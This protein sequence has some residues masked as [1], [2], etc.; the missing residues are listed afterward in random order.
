MPDIEVKKYGPIFDGSIYG[1]MKKAMA[2]ID[3]ALG[4]ETVNEVQGIDDATF[5]HPTGNARSKVKATRTKGAVTVDRSRLIYGP[6]L[7][8][9]GS[10]SDIF[11]G[12]HA[13]ERARRRVD[14]RAMDIA[15]NIVSDYLIQ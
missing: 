12:Y 5:V 15:D 13:F 4:E 11:S 6:W 9:G 10:R 14:E 8:D 1:Q 3:D 7:E 2:D